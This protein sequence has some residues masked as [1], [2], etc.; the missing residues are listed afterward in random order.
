MKKLFLLTLVL[1]LVV[2]LGGCQRGVE[3]FDTSSASVIRWFD[4]GID[5]HSDDTETRECEISA[6]PDVTFLRD[7][8]VL[9]V[10]DSTAKTKLYSGMPIW[11]V[12]FCDLNGD[13]QPEICST[14]SVGSGMIDNRIRV[15]DYAAK[16]CY[17]LEDRGVY[18]YALNI[19]DGVLIYE[20]RNY[21]DNYQDDKIIETGTLRIEDGELRTC[22]Q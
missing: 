14:V 5:P 8:T 20:K 15:Y 13:S 18:D 11:S 17:E 1:A 12:Y 9:Y 21:R 2:P 6:F 4:Y 7:Y 16:A 22:P 10:L 3:K 19:K